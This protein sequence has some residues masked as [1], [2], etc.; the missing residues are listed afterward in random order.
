MYNVRLIEP[1]VVVVV[2]CERWTLAAFPE[3]PK[4]EDCG[5]RGRENYKTPNP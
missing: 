4:V 3:P 2:L 1:V 5:A